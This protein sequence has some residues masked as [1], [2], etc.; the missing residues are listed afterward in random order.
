MKQELIVAT[1]NAGKAREFGQLLGDAWEVKTL[2]DIGWTNEI[3]ETG[4][5]FVE[6]AGIKATTISKAYP[7]QWVL[8]DDSGL[9]VDALEMRPGVYSA[10]YAGEPKDDQRNLDKVIDEMKDIPEAQRGAQF[11]CV[12]AL[13]KGGVVLENFNGIVRGT[14]TN[15]EHGDGGFGYDPI[16]IPEGFN[17]T[18]GV[19]PSET[20]HKLSHRGKAARQLA[21]YLQREA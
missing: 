21:E 14:L 2:K 8:A 11:H 18:F 17:E 20:K 9:E 5:T 12:L 1:G 13:A 15:E 19:L 6:N 16:F 7:D 4:T 3:E 10:R